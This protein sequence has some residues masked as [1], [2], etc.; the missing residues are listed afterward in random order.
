MFYELTSGQ[1]IEDEA[2]SERMNRLVEYRPHENDTTYPWDH[3]GIATLLDDIY[4]DTIRYCPENG[5]W[6]IMD[7]CWRKQVGDITIAEK[8]QELLNLLLLYCSEMFADA[9][10]KSDD[11]AC[12]RIDDYR[13][14][15]TTQRR[16][17]NLKG[18]V[19]VL[20]TLVYIHLTSMDTNPYLLNTPNLAYDLR[21]NDIIPDITSYNVTK[22]T[23]CTMPDFTT[24]RCDRWYQ[25]ID[26]IMSHDQQKA[27][28]LQRA[29]G[30]SILGVNREECMF[31]AY[32]AK[33]RNGK[34][35]LFSTITTV[36]G[37]DYA[38]SAPVDLICEGKGGKTTD[39][40]AP[41][42]ALAK[43]V[44]T[45]LVT[46]SESA[47][48]VRLDAASMKTITGRD[49]LV[50][51]G[52]YKD[53]FSFVPQF[54]L[55]LNTNHLPAVTDDTVFSSDRIWVIEFNEHFDTSTQNKDLK[56]IFAKHENRP[57]ILKWLVDGCEDYM[58]NGLN[59]PKCVR[60]AT[61]SYRKLHDRIGN[62]IDESCV[63]DPNKS[64]MRGTLYSAYRQWCSKGENKYTPLGST[65]FYNEI[66]MRGYAPKKKADG[67]YIAG[68]DL[69]QTA[70]MDGRIQL[71]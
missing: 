26:E 40:N 4:K 46:M 13:K 56:E 62:F 60:D 71:T 23:S 52:L 10:A 9:T 14:F 28:F 15:L 50:T 55:W 2:L 30:Y 20:K 49:T 44:G 32:G 34:G 39:Y 51:R 25:Y 68:L 57:T 19:E 3:I 29:L 69:S 43:L 37:E 22:M 16:Y 1:V 42:P 67:W 33:T 6:Y 5:N 53:S 54:T 48:D 27:R 11:A 12:K 47:K 64:V 41:Q 17:N 65:T 61:E 36:L 66:G 45:R 58:R 31:I 24:T 59:P 35:T 63:A 7:G 21:T 38:D 18:I 70:S 8:L